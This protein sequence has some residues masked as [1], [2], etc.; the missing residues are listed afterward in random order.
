MNQRLLGGLHRTC[1]QKLHPSTTKT[2]VS[3]LTTNCPIATS[4]SLIFLNF[5]WYRILHPTRRHG[6]TRFLHRRRG[7]CLVNIPP[8]LHFVLAS[9]TDPRS[10]ANLSTG[11]ACL[12]ETFGFRRNLLISST[13]TALFA[14]RNSIFLIVTFDLVPADIRFGL[15]SKS[16]SSI[17]SP[18]LTH[19]NQL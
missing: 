9:H 6:A 2:P 5:I 12:G 14:S 15:P 1:S 19:T 16:S 17:S 8:A 11:V 13:S 4:A 7:R 10:S 18:F 3:L